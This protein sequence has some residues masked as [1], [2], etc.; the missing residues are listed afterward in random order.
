[1]EVVSY[2]NSPCDKVVLPTSVRKGDVLFIVNFFGLK[3]AG[4]YEKARELG[5]PVIED[6]S[7]D[8]WSQWAIHSKADYVLVSLRKTLPIPDGGAIAT[9]DTDSK[10]WTGSQLLFQ[11]APSPNQAMKRISPAQIGRTTLFSGVCFSLA[12]F[13]MPWRKH[14]SDDE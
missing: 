4:D 10:T 6:H 13:E 2:S 8:P 3:A 11:I 1:M 12:D 9:A 5:I 7:H 14:G